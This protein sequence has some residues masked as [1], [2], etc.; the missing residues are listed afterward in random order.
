M[1]VLS[2]KSLCVCLSFC[3][4]NY[5]AQCLSTPA[6]I[7]CLRIFFVLVSGEWAVPALPQLYHHLSQLSTDQMTVTR[8]YLTVNQI[9]FCLLLSPTPPPV[10][11]LTRLPATSFRLLI[12]CLGVYQSHLSLMLD[13]ICLPVFIFKSVPVQPDLVV[14][15][16]PFQSTAGWL[17]DLLSWLEL[18]TAVHH[19]NTQSAHSAPRWPLALIL[20]AD[21]PLISSTNLQVFR[22]RPLFGTQ[23]LWGWIVQTHF[24]N[25]YECIHT[26]NKLV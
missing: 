24:L 4:W 10:S 9:S 1:T 7:Y 11:L 6:V 22:T 21:R 18:P 14:V 26:E 3:S 5:K 2:G 15:C 20:S 16:G 13:L 19:I 23:H 12:V 17:T 25:V 8:T